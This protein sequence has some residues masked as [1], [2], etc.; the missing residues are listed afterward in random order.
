MIDVADLGAVAV[1][2]LIAVLVTLGVNVACGIGTAR[3]FG[4]NQRAA[5]NVGLTVV[6]RGEFSLILAT[7]ALAAGLDARLGPFVALYVLILAVL[8]PLLASQSQYLARIIPDRVLRSGWR[9]VR[10]ETITTSCT[11]LDQIHVTETD[12]DVCAQCLELG[13]DWVEL[14]LCLTCGHVGCCDDSPNHHAS[15]HAEA[16]GHPLIQTLQPGED[17]RYCFIDQTLVHEP[18]R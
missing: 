13:D 3:L 15:R 5:A 14:R 1:P 12:V 4:F 7:I 10:E 11:H 18:S 8:S 17:W 9:Y 2:V 16:D 6:G